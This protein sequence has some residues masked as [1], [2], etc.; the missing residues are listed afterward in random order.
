MKATFAGLNQ[1]KDGLNEKIQNLELL[2]T[3]YRKSFQAFLDMRDDLYRAL[4][5][6]NIILDAENVSIVKTGDFSTWNEGDY[7]KYSMTLQGNE[8]FKFLKENNKMDNIKIKA[9][10]MES[11][12]NDSFITKYN[13]QVNYFSLLNDSKCILIDF[14]IH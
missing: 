9:K 13:F 12:L 7:F 3:N 14:W 2:K 5:K 6:L 11:V 10:K 1:L 8:K 4:T